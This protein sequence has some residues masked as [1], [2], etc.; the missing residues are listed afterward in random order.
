MLLCKFC[1]EFAPTF[2]ET[3]R[4]LAPT[5]DIILAEIDIE[6][7][8][9]PVQLDKLPSLFMISK[10]KNEE[11]KK[12]KLMYSDDRNLIDLLTFIAQTSGTSQ[13]KFVDEEF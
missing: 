7:N 6:K 13:L 4:I 1:K 5:E 3:A 10:K 8:T 2:E 11:G 9:I 12:I